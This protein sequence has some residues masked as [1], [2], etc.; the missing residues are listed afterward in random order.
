MTRHAT[1]LVVG[2]FCPL[3][4]GHQ[5]LLDRARAQCG[6]L[7]VISYTRPEFE[8]C[9]PSR[10]ERWL[11]AT[12]P[13]AVRLVLDDARLARRCRTQ[14]LEPRILP[15]NEDDDRTHRHFVAWLLHAV[16]ET[17]VDAVFT[18][19]DYGDGFAAALSRSQ[20]ARGGP[21]V[22]HVAVD[23]ERGTFPVSGTRVRADIHGHRRWL[24]PDVY[25]DLVGS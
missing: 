16:L 18:S 13:D 20:Q 5:Y 12:V 6:K 14:G 19:E 9:G 25:R 22:A 3:H 2:K 1:G 7:V 21:A 24:A 23:P 10:R 11:A 8:G 17:D 15:A 4:R